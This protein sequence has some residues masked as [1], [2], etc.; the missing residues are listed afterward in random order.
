MAIKSLQLKHFRNFTDLSLKFDAGFNFFFGQN[1]QGKTNII[2]AIHYIADLKS[3]RASD[4]NDLIQH[5]A[6]FAHLK[7]HIE[8]DEL[9]S[10]IDITLNAAHKTV[11]VNGVG[12]VKRMQG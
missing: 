12:K 11:L 3:F 10:E 8:K 1:A 6:E 9:T 5:G 2:E 4:K 7:A